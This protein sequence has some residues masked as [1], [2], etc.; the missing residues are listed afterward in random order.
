MCEIDCIMRDRSVLIKINV[1]FESKLQ[2]NAIGTLVG[3]PNKI[4]NSTITFSC[5]GTV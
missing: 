2:C 4:K 1:R 3:S 5:A